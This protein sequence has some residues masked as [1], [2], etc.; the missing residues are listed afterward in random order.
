MPIPIIAYFAAT[1]AIG[2][3]AACAETSPEPDNSKPEPELWPCSTAN[4]EKTHFCTVQPAGIPGVK[5]EGK[6]IPVQPLSGTIAYFRDICPTGAADS[7]TLTQPNDEEMRFEASAVNLLSSS[8]PGDK[9]TSSLVKGCKL[10]VSCSDESS[11][12]LDVESGKLETYTFEDATKLESDLKIREN[13]PK[14]SLG[15]G[16]FRIEDSTLLLNYHG[17]QKTGLIGYDLKT[18]TSTSYWQQE[19]PGSHL[20]TLHSVPLSEGKFLITIDEHRDASILG[21]NR[22]IGYSVL[23]RFLGAFHLQTKRMEFFVTLPDELI[24]YTDDLTSEGKSWEDPRYQNYIQLN[25]SQPILRPEAI[26]V[27]QQPFFFKKIPNSDFPPVTEP[28]RS[29]LLRIDPSTGRILQTIKLPLYSGIEL[30]AIEGTSKIAISG[31]SDPAHYEKWKLYLFDTSTNTLEKVLESAEGLQPTFSKDG[32]LF[33]A[34]EKY[35]EYQ[36]GQYVPIS[37][38]LIPKTEVNFPYTF[39]ELPERGVLPFESRRVAG[40]AFKNWEFFDD[41]YGFSLAKEIDATEI[42][43]GNHRNYVVTDGLRQEA[44]SFE[45][46]VQDPCYYFHFYVPGFGSHISEFSCD[47]EAGAA[48]FYQ[49]Q[50]FLGYKNALWRVGKNE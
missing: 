35:Y 24:L 36:N 38:P 34:N 28:A 50:I 16:F 29:T 5:I 33:E 43:V 47:L 40:K 31:R 6:S 48:T 20:G 7:Y 14:I 32:I 18:R 2:L 23:N 46:P 26:W 17:S 19:F 39:K 44:F 22:E 42:H 37:S 13:D 49:G 30:R 15:E 9:N 3:V 1:L 10:Y 11:H 12:F 27:T 4:D 41:L 21:S 45:L 25:Y 8:C